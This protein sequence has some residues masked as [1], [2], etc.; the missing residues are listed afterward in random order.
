[1][2]RLLVLG[3]VVGL[4]GGS[5][6]AATP[7]EAVLPE[8]VVGIATGYFGGLGGASVF[9]AVLAAGGFG[10]MEATIL[11]TVL[12]Y[13]GGTALGAS[14]GVALAGSLLGVKGNVRLCFLGG[15]RSVSLIVS[16]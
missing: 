5:L 4:S 10:G 9:P 8:L 1:M 14:L 11:G 7:E 6:L 15:L 13:T 12:G 3:M 2:R 16:G